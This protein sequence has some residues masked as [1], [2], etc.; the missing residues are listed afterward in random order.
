MD[1]LAPLLIIAACIAGSF[2]LAKFI[3]RQSDSAK[4]AAVAAM[5]AGKLFSFSTRA[6]LRVPDSPQ[7][8]AWWAGRLLINDAVVTWQ[9]T[10]SFRKPAVL[11]G[12]RLIDERQYELRQA[13]DNRLSPNMRIFVF[14]TPS[15]MVELALRLADSHLVIEAM[16]GSARHVASAAGR[17]DAPPGAPGAGA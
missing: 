7:R 12:A 2:F 10:G 1:I 15:G 9:G 4:G 8:S 17:G 11:T 5:Y 13:A 14:E 16:N 6:W 3:R